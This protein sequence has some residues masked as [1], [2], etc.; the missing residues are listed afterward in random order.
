M[1]RSTKH[2][3][4]AFGM[5]FALLI[6]S[7]GGSSSQQPAAVSPPPSASAE[8]AT[9]QPSASAESATSQPTASAESATSQPTAS[10]ELAADEDAEG[11][12]IPPEVPPTT[13]AD[14]R[15]S[16][17]VVEDFADGPAGA[18]AADMDGDNE[19]V[20]TSYETHEVLIFSLS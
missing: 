6:S 8:S 7:C 20:F 10:A 13:A 18:E 16:I 4:L 2:V 1:F 15:F 9:S 14:Q 19:V 5:A 3:G 17:T 12:I 11:N